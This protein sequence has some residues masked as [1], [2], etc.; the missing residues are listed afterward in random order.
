MFASSVEITFNLLSKPL[1]K[2][3]NAL[4]SESLIL[5]KINMEPSTRSPTYSRICAFI[6]F[7]VFASELNKEAQALSRS[8][9]LQLRK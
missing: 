2:F 6:A 8:L 7:E 3:A 5:S 1:A 9:H 4:R